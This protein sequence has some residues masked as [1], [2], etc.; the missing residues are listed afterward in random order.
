MNAKYSIITLTL[1][2]IDF[3]G[4]LASRPDNV[5]F[6]ALEKE[7]PVWVPVW[8]SAELTLVE[9]LL[10]ETIGEE[11]LPITLKHRT[12][13]EGYDD[14]RLMVSPL[15]AIKAAKE[16]MKAVIAAAAAA[17]VAAATAATA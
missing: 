15:A 14:Y 17:E 2:A 9:K 4:G 1:T 3:R 8:D 12:N 16:R 5:I 11:G 6:Y 10:G 7:E 13:D